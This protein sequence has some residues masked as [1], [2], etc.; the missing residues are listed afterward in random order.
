MKKENG[1][2]LWKVVVILE[3]E[4]IRELTK[5]FSSKI[6]AMNYAVKMEARTYIVKDCYDKYFGAPYYYVPGQKLYYNTKIVKW[7]GN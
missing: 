6:A 4:V 1:V 2:Y 3:G 5:V 7:F